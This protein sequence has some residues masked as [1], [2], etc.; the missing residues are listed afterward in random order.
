MKRIAWVAFA[1]LVAACDPSAS[2]TPSSPPKPVALTVLPTADEIAGRY[3]DVSTRKSL[4]K[5]LML[6]AD[7]TFTLT[8]QES[9]GAPNTLTGAWASRQIPASGMLEL[10][11]TPFFMPDGKTPVDSLAMP[12]ER[13]GAVLCFTNSDIGVFVRVP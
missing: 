13:C 1:W 2:T 11:V 3:D 5:T 4:R 7:G 9:G 12:I 10:K 8:T 6:R